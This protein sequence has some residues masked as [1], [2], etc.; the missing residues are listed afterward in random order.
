MPIISHPSCPSAFT[1]GTKSRL[2]GSHGT[3]L[4][5]VI[6]R[7]E[8]FCVLRRLRTESCKKLHTVTSLGS[9]TYDRLGDDLH[10]MESRAVAQAVSCW[11]PTEADSVR[12]RA[13]CGVCGALGQVFSEYFGFPCQSFHQFLHY[14]NHLGLAQ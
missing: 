11:L 14:H 8:L 4:S 7:S 6:T 2:R 13:A 10:F 9:A 12:I 5:G 1:K 3:P